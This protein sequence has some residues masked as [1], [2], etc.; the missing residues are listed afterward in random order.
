MKRFPMNNPNLVG[1][2]GTPSDQGGISLNNTAMEACT[3]R[4]NRFVL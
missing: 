2:I 4:T 3:C 1:R